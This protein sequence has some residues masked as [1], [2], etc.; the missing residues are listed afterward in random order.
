M[1]PDSSILDVTTCDTFQMFQ[2]NLIKLII[3]NTM[4]EAEIFS[5]ILK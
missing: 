2:L 5:D 3:G 1:F 4:L